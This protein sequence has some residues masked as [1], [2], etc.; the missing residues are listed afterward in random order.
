MNALQPGK[1]N[2]F[3]QHAD[4]LHLGKH[5]AKFDLAFING[6]GFTKPNGLKAKANRCAAMRVK[7]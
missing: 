5:V 1:K 4:A 7:N 2:E 3:L 6:L